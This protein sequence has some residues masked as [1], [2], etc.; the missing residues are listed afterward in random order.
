MRITIIR[1]ILE[2]WKIELNKI[3]ACTTDCGANILAA[4]KILKFIN[5]NCF[6][7][8]LNNAV[9]K[10]LSIS[11]V[12]DTLEKIKKI[13]KC[14]SHSSK[15][16]R[17]LAAQQA[18]AGRTQKSFPS[19]TPTRWWSILGLMN[20]CVEEQLTLITLFQKDS[21]RKKLILSQADIDILNAF[22]ALIK[23]FADMSEHLSSESNVTASVLLPLLK[24]IVEN[25][26]AIMNEKTESVMTEDLVTDTPDLFVEPLQEKFAVIVSEVL[27]KRYINK[28]DDR[29]LDQMKFLKKAVLFDPRFKDEPDVEDVKQEIKDE[30]SNIL[31]Y[32]DLNTHT[33]STNKKGLASLLKRKRESQPISKIQLLE[34]EF[35]I[36]INN[37]PAVGL[38]ANPLTW[39]KTSESSLLN[40]EKSAKR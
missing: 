3:V 35:N 5:I 37:M 13:Y 6:G 10:T 9:S 29:I 18:V 19:Y 11:E 7:H 15:M 36:Y 23:P 33:E 8:T 12:Q 27:K 38:E 40:L 22:V 34:H 14:F 2:D 17:E 25:N 1:A 26:L 24:N 39:W 16:Q 20:A 21:Q 32:Q 30:L 31:D 4:M 28:D